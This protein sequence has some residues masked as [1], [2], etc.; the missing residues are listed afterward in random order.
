MIIAAARRLAF[1][2]LVLLTLPISVSAQGA[3]QGEYRQFDFWIGE[4]DILNR[5]RP[6]EEARWYDTGSATARVYPVVF[7]CGIVEHWRGQAYGEFQVGLSF[8]AFNP[9]LG[10]WDMVL[11]WPNT[12]Q[13]RFGE[14]AGGFRLNR[15]E[16]YSRGLSETGDTTITRFT[17][18]DIGSDALRWQ[19]GLSTDGGRSWASG[20]IQEFSRREPLYQ[21]PLL[22]GPSVT[23]LRC[24]GPEF[25][26]MDFLIGEWEGS[27]AADTVETEGMGLLADVAPILEGCGMMERISAIGQNSAWEVFRVRAFEPARNSWVEYRLDSRWPILQRLEA[28]VSPAGA[29]WVFQ[30]TMNRGVDGRVTW[31]EERY[32]AETSQWEASPMVIY[33]QRLGGVSSEGL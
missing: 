31:E 9:Q 23:T 10:Q 27:T 29:P 19:D 8:Q 28:A 17:F 13:P 18:S 11:L 6:E 12:G 4:W 2:L 21:G 3:C 26:G 24:P 7:G 1:A 32:N 14:L 22:N 30:V 33:S 20:W 5:N 16:F 25:R 15:G